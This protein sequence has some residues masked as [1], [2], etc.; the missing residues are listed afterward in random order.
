MFVDSI[1]IIIILVFL[2]LLLL[3]LFAK[4]KLLS[5]YVYVWPFLDN[6]RD[7]FGQNDHIEYVYFF[8]SDNFIVLFCDVH[9][10]PPLQNLQSAAL[11]LCVIWGNA[12]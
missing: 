2:L 9:L 12:I 3:L 7:T 4:C 11:C 1:I 10:S 5:Y 8:S 6:I